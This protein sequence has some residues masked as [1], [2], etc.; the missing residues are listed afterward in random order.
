M[1]EPTITADMLNQAIADSRTPEG[2]AKML[3]T[4]AA[5][6]GQAVGTVAILS[7]C[8]S[9]VRELH[10]AAERM[11][12]AYTIVL[13]Q[14]YGTAKFGD[15]WW[16]GNAH[17]YIGEERGH[18]LAM[19]LDPGSEMAHQQMA[20]CTAVYDDESETWQ[21]PGESCP[22]CPNLIGEGEA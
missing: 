22:V 20:G 4:L 19:L 14:E 3:D 6:G 16:P 18:T 15:E 12:L 10:S 2:I 5:R 9:R 1:S 13:L 8:A 21:H 17:P 7:G 11:D